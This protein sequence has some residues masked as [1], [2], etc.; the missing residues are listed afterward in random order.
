V[1]L[2]SFKTGSAIADTISIKK[3]SRVDS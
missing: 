1:R 2:N 3:Q